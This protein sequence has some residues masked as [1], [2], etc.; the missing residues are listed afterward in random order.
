MRVDGDHDKQLSRSA[1]SL[2][3]ASQCLG[4]GSCEDDSPMRTRL[5]LPQLNDAL[6]TWLS[7]SREGKKA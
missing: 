4:N 6:A 5:T 3:H 7:M 2:S 1:S